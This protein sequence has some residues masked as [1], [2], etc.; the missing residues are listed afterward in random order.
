MRSEFSVSTAH[1][2]TV[3]FWGT[4]GS[5]PC[6][7]R[8]YLRYGGNTACVEVRV[9]SRVFI[10][11]AG[12][13]LAN[14][15]KALMDQA[16]HGFDIL[17]SHLHHDHISGLPFFSPAL[18]TGT[19]MRIHC[20]NLDGRSAEDALNRMFAP[21]LFPIALSAL[22]ARFTYHGFRAGTPLDFG[23]G[24][25]VQTCLLDHPGG[26]TA[27]RFDHG[28]RSLC[29]ISDVEH[30]P[31]IIDDDLVTFCHEADLVIYDTMFNESEF[32]NC[33]GWG[34]STWAAGVELCRAADAKALAAT[35][36]HIGHTDDMLDNVAAQVK[37]ALPGSFVAREGQ[38]VRFAARALA[39]AA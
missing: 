39:P 30:R 1:A 34:H 10:V 13:G 19:N 5:L 33:R 26:A 9:G 14:A 28:G 31:G 8:E 27:F 20:G 17:L 36:H 11:D 25:V 18:K 29:Y 12:S 22:P 7:G 3:R 24:I 16:P 15:G 32:M 37:S 21:P 6:P 38:V 35:H 23:D 4:R 2:L